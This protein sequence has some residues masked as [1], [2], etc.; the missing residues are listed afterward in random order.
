VA[1]VTTLDIVGTV[2]AVLFV[3]LTLF[4]IWQLGKRD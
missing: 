3:A 1:G 2:A 4:L